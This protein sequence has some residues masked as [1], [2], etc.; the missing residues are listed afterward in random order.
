[1][2]TMVNLTG[3]IKIDRKMITK[4]NLTGDRK[5]DSNIT[6]M[7]NFANVLHQVFAA[8]TI[9]TDVLLICPGVAMA[10]NSIA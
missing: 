2:I 3:K 8:A 6:R 1:M 10:M 5:K 4:V 9:L 7:I